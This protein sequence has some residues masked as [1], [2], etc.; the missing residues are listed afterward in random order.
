[1]ATFTKGHRKLGGRKPGTPNKF[2]GVVKDAVLETFIGLGG[3]EAMTAWARRNK[4][5]FYRLAAR[6]IPLEMKAETTGARG[7]P[8]VSAHAHVH[9]H[10]GIGATLTPEDVAAAKL[11]L[12]RHSLPGRIDAFTDAFA[13]AADREATQ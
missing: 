13:G 11:L 12:E 5:Q 10:V 7:G 2:T 1:M 9:A 8:V 4:T 3:V 6:L